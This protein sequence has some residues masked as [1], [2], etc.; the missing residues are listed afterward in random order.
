MVDVSFIS[1]RF[2]GADDANESVTAPGVHHAENFRI[3]SAESN[4]ANLAIVLPVVDP[5]HDLVGEDLSSG[6][7]R[8]AM[9]G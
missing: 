8:N 7:K 2:L 3:R 9:F 4:P 1:A 5:L 6:Q